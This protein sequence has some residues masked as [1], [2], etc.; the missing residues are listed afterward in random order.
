MRNRLQRIWHGRLRFLDSED[1]PL[2]IAIIAIWYW[3][4]AS[5]SIVVTI[6]SLV[7]AW[8]SPMPHALTLPIPSDTVTLT[9]SIPPDLISI[10]ERVGPLVFTGM[11]ASALAA[12]LGYG[13]WI[14]HGATFWIVV[15]LNLIQIGSR[16][17]QDNANTTSEIVTS[18]IA[19][20][21]VGYLLRPRI[22]AVYRYQG[23]RRQLDSA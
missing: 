16:L 11:V 5:A 13:L 2:G 8:R 20:G 15:A 19:L 7:H 4:L 3:L 18:L 9:A 1:R 10:T 23:Q 14:F 12:A 17:L 22:R 6:L 21:I